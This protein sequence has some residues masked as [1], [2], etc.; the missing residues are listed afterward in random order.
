M[1]ASQ[2]GVPTN[3][4]DATE[5]VN[6]QQAKDQVDQGLTRE[7]SQPVNVSQDQR[8]PQQPLNTVVGPDQPVT[9]PA[10][11]D[12]QQPDE[13]NPQGHQ[14]VRQDIAAEG[15]NSQP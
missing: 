11:Q 5:E 10:Q 3:A 7:T 13:P 4:A 9:D 1:E 15:E 8:V 12:P 2:P 14:Q 6:Q